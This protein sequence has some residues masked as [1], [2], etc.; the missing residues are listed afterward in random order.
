MGVGPAAA[1]PA[2]VKAAGLELDDIDLFEIN[3]VK[4]HRTTLLSISTPYVLC[5]KNY[6]V[7]LG[8]CI[9]VCLLSEQAGARPGEDQCQWRGYSHWTSLRRYRY[10]LHPCSP[11]WLVSSIEQTRLC[12]TFSGARCVAT[13]LHEMKR[14]GK[15]CRFGVVSMCI[16]MFISH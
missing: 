12:C 4:K 3:E 9:S 6:C 8:I 15:D 5:L 2:A 1:I 13:L 14:R 11:I 7:C 16:G 10:M